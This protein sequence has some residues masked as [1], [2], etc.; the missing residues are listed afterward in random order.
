MSARLGLAA[1]AAL[2]L[3]CFA[4]C[5]ERDPRPT[6]TLY[7][8][9]DDYVLREVVA[10][11]EAQTGIAVDVL[12]D[13]EATKTFGLVERLL[14]ERESPQAD[15]WWSSEPFGTIRLDDA[16]VF[17]SYPPGAPGGWPETLI[18]PEARWIGL[19][20][21]ARVIAYNT[22]L[23]DEA[24]VP[25]RLRD[26]MDDEWRGRVGIARPEFGTTRGHVAALTHAVGAEATRAWLE[27]LVG[28]RL[29]VYDGNAAAVRAVAQGEIALCLTDTDDVWAGQRNGWPVALVYETIDDA[30]TIAGLDTRAGDLPSLGALVLPNTVALVG[31]DDNPEAV[32]FV[33]W[34]LSGEAERIMARSDSRNIPVDA[35]VL[36]EFAE[37][38]VP[39]PWRVDLP[40]VARAM[41]Q[42]MGVA[43]S[44][45]D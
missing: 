39:T 22:E 15:V 35:E 12:G 41:P 1:V 16:G 14:A 26:L 40:V 10:A 31:Q 43:A 36:A 2:L 28:S 34:L 3:L 9:V 6:I 4:S 11:F 44:A 33:A 5:A 42:A 24:D 13:T 45:L 8:S 32:E 21:R 18:G 30:E 23:V 29:R 25:T 37:L 7:S 38:A 17:R 20:E 27:R 19:A